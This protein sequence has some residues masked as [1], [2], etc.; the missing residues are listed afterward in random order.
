MPYE[1]LKHTADVRLRVEGETLERLFSDALEGMMEIIKKSQVPI[2][3]DQSPKVKRAVSVQAGD[4]T[5]LLVD[6]LNEV[7]SLSQ[8]NKEVYPAVTFDELSETSLKGGLEGVEVGEFD[9]DIKAVTYHEAEIKKNPAG[10][11]ETILI[12]DI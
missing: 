9:E 12:F 4:K 6:F 3:N 1:I 8:I 2:P 10:N 11:W 7:L 5:A